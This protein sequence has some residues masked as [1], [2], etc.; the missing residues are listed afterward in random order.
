MEVIEELTFRGVNYIL[1]DRSKVKTEWV[2][3]AKAAGATDVFS[4]NDFYILK[5]EASQKK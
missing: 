4:N 3:G 1:I 2:Q 5:L